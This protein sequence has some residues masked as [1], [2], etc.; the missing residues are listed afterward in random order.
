MYKKGIF[1]V[2]D[3]SYVSWSEFVRRLWCRSR[4]L[5]DGIFFEKIWVLSISNLYEPFF[6]VG[7]T[8]RV[9]DHSAFEIYHIIII[10]IIIHLLQC[11]MYMKLHYILLIRI[12]SLL[13]G[14]GRSA[15]CS[16]VKMFIVYIDLRIEYSRTIFVSS[17][18]HV[19]FQ[20]V[21]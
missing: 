17:V 11:K 15:I 6:F 19:S 21:Y 4:I 20:W 9:V 14:S 1:R 7:T 13:H 16:T 5:G 10:I 12:A 18:L 8:N 2:K 3:L